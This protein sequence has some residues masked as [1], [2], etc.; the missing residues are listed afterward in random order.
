[1]KKEILKKQI[2]YSRTYR[3]IEMDKINVFLGVFLSIIPLCL[4][5]LFYYPQITL[6]ISQFTMKV[7]SPIFHENVLAIESSDFLKWFGPVYYLSLPGRFP[8]IVFIWLNLLIT[9]ISLFLLSSVVKTRPLTIFLSISL[10]VHVCS[11]IFFTFIPEYFPY[12]ATEYSSLYIK[13]QVGI[14]FFVPIIIGIAVLHCLP[15][16]LL[17][18]LGLTICF[19]V[20]C[21][22]FLSLAF[23]RYIHF[24]CSFL[25]KVSLMYMASLFFSF[26]PFIDFFVF[27]LHFIVCLPAVP[28]IN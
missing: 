23:V 28:Q 14:Y 10:W 8:S 4:L 18:S 9:L 26:G 19:F 20:A 7:L 11:A 25:S 6:F 22:F 1:M 21:L 5:V 24:L 15:Y 16:K 27:S 12:D 2:Q 13:Q 3:Y 17:L